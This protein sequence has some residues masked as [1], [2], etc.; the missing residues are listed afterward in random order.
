MKIIFEIS[1]MDYG[2]LVEQF[3]PMVRDKL[4]EKD[5]TGMVILSKIAGMPTSFAGKMIDMLPQ[6]S[7]DEIAVLLVNKNKEKIIDSVMEYADKK[8]LSFHID[9]FEVK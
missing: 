4:A 8:G 3:L 1:D 9:N 7:N 2:A 6:E 5:N